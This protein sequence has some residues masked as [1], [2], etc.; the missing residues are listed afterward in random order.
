[1]A[2]PLNFFS[3]L[4]QSRPKLNLDRNTFPKEMGYNLAY[5]T[6]KTQY[7]E[8]MPLNPSLVI[9]EEIWSDLISLYQFSIKTCHELT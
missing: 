1:M 3:C 9:E 8:K 4:K 5:H 7:L 6:D 2:V